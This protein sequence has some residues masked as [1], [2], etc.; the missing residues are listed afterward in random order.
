MGSEASRETWAVPGV[1]ANA[2]DLAYARF[3]RAVTPLA[4]VIVAFVYYSEPVC[5]CFRRPK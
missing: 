4:S 5:L 3:C 2:V 1:R